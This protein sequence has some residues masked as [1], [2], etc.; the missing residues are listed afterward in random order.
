MQRRVHKTNR[1]T[2]G[3]FKNP[4]ASVDLSKYTK[5][6]VNAELAYGESFKSQAHKGKAYKVLF[7]DHPDLIYISF[8]GNR[9]KAI[10]EGC[11]YFRDNF[12]PT[13]MGEGLMEEVTKAQALRV[14]ELDKF[15]GDRKVPIPDLMKIMGFTFP[16]SVCGE[17]NFTYELY[18]I[19]ACFIVEGE[20][21]LNAFTSGYVLCYDCYKKYIQSSN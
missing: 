1:G 6:Q 2:T 20:G 12:Y 18:E 15:A 9:D 8:K 5:P 14:P 3:S 13:F 10:Y 16:C 19:G 21:D 17:H 11:K 7:K 4:F